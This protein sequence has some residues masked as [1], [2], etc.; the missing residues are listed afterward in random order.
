MTKETANN[1]SEISDE[2]LDDVSGGPHFRTWDI[3]PH[4]LQSSD[5]KGSTEST[6]NQ[7]D[8]SRSK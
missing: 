4:H 7:W 8:V 5:S 3:G 2:K 1:P 6:I